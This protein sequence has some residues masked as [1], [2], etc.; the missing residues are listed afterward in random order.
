[1]AARA[2][3]EWQERISDRRDNESG[4]RMRRSGKRG[5]GVK[6]GRNRGEN[7]ERTTT[8]TP[9]SFVR[10]GEI[11]TANRVGVHEGERREPRAP[12]R[13]RLYEEGVETRDLAERVRT[14]EREWVCVCV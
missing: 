2:R 7:T 9:F 4:R 3:A 5:N 13:A 6:T 11:E 1:M 10:R 8:G 12:R 14:R